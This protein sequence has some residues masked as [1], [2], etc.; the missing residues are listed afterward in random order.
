MNKVTNDQRT[1]ENA[2]PMTE[3][4]SDCGY[5]S[6]ANATTTATNDSWQDET[7]ISD[8]I[9]ETAGAS[10]FSLSLSDRI[11]QSEL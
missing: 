1:P 5:D 4:D 3:T 11:T 7:D 10:I 6:S 2:I 9:E 8:Q